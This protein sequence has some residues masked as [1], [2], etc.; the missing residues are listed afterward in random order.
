MA[1][2]STSGSLASPGLGSGLDINAIVSKLMA[3]E[4]QPLT[5]LAAKEASYQARITAFGTL[6]GGLSALQ[7]ALAGLLDARN[8][9]TASATLADPTLATV[10]AGTAAVPGS[11]S[12]RVNALAQA[13]KIASTGFASGATAG[14]ASPGES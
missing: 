9:K 13:H 10:T 1:V 12:V 6:K 3:V 4:S 8:M 14:T 2:D 7:A 5:A 11:Y